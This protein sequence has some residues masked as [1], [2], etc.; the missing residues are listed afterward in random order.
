LSQA[1]ATA[2]AAGPPLF[3]D[4]HAD[5]RESFRTF[6]EREVKPA[7]S[8]WSEHGAVPQELLELAGEHGFL[9]MRV[10]EQN[11]GA[12][13]DDLRFGV[14]VG[15][16]AMLAGAPA[17]ALV[18]G[19][20]N[21][22]ALPA[23][24]RG[25]PEDWGAERLGGLASGESVATVADGE[26]KAT[27]DGETT[28]L[29]GTA[30]MVLGA[31]RAALIVV[32]A[33][34]PGGERLVALLDRDADGVSVGAAEPAIGLDAASMA[35]VSLSGARALVI[36][37]S[38]EADELEIDRSLM[39]AVTALAGTR[40]ALAITREYVRER[41]AFGQPIASFQ[42]TRRLLGGIAADAE[43]GAAFIERAVRRR[44]EGSLTTADAS[45]GK[46]FCTEL[47]GR[48]VDAGVQMHGGYGYIMEYEIAHAFADAR[49]WRL[50]GTTNQTAQDRIGRE[51]LA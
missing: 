50:A 25:A 35:T 27:R 33:E 44:L 7:Y 2:G 8:R 51:L 29:D 28:A 1:G 6:C 12:G 16:E 31:P 18:L 39:L 11:G 14:V 41:M 47:Y 21:D 30:P 24:L 45:A 9:G 40:A 42:N 4:E 22:V 5:Y 23:I 10:P 17:L 32:L 20:H 34:D 46:L 43:V 26:L 36:G 37:G 13:V 3:D 48:A 49:F 15:E 19:L 38:A